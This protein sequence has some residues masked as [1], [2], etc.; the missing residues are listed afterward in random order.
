MSHYLFLVLLLIQT[1][2]ISCR[3]ESRN[4]CSNG[5]GGKLDLI[6]GTS[7]YLFHDKTEVFLD[8]TNLNGLNF[9]FTCH[10]KDNVTEIILDPAKLKNTLNG[11]NLEKKI[12]KCQE[13]CEI[14]V[15]I[16]KQSA[17]DKSCNTT[18]GDVNCDLKSLNRAR[19]FT[20][21]INFSPT[22]RGFP[23]RNNATNATKSDF[24]PVIKYSIMDPVVGE[25]KECNETD[26]E[27]SVAKVGTTHE[28]NV[29]FRN[30]DCPIDNDVQT[31]RPA[32]IRVEKVQNTR[33]SVA[34]EFLQPKPEPEYSYI[35]VQIT[36]ASI[37]NWPK[38]KK[39]QRKKIMIGSLVGGL[40]A[41]ILGLCGV[42]AYIC[43]K[44]YKKGEQ[45][46]YH[47]T[48]YTGYPKSA[49]ANS[50]NMTD[51][52]HDGYVMN[53]F[54][55]F[56]DYLNQDY[57]KPND[58]SEEAIKAR[59]KIISRQISGDPAKLNPSMTLN[60]QIKLLQYNDD[61]E[62]HRSKFTIGQLLGSGNFG[63][64]YEGS[65]A[66]LFHPG[67]D[68]KVAI[69][70]VNDAFD[71][72]QITALISEIKVLGHLDLHLNLVNM[73]GSCRSQLEEEGQLWLLLEYCSEGDL[74][75][76]MIQHREEFI[77]SMTNKIQ[78]N[79]LDD[80]LFLKW[81]LHI[82]KGNLKTN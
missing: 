35:S 64:V 57:W 34:L 41:V 29:N 47:P 39:W 43:W 73:M 65:A 46:A 24:T 55:T 7:K 10:T 30:I 21:Y 17:D 49:F 78:V 56:D 27:G 19:N 68:T 12:V 1:W 5:A 67:S 26:S 70:T 69:K 66:G 20:P 4:L 8:G 40:T 28:N 75:S 54:N 45:K 31:S 63:S 23:E 59:K 38:V 37:K 60:Q 52:T 48:F 74:K 22:V 9:T 77:S 25:W 79:E 36:E 44:K 81:G 58:N 6:E 42:L 2:R 3:P 51:S 61:H 76:F 18:D 11:F 13:V 50:M 82:A 72:L 53:D 62:M 15:I 71:G 16:I 80:R 33:Q 14:G 32:I